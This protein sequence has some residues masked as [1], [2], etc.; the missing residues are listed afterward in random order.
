MIKWPP[1]LNQSLN[2]HLS[3]RTMLMTGLVSLACLV[4]ATWSWSTWCRWR[5]APQ[6]FLRFVCVSDVTKETDRNFSIFCTNVMKQW[7]KT[8]ESST[9]AA[10]FFMDLFIW[11]F[12]FFYFVFVIL[13]VST[14]VYI[15]SF[16]KRKIIVVWFLL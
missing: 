16:V 4:W 6:L 12:L 15:R 11:S 3:S 1:S 7:L 9:A 14:V 8:A 13:S 2:S 5:G 10:V